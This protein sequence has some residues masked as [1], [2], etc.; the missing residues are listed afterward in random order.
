MSS[1]LYYNRVLIIIFNQYEI[2]NNRSEK[3]YELPYEH[4]KE[5]KLKI[6][7]RK[8][9]MDLKSARKKLKTKQ[10]RR[11][12][13][14][15]PHRGSNYNRIMPNGVHA[16]ITAKSNVGKKKTNPEKAPSLL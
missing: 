13:R 9:R 6:V 5:S 15:D 11:F 16:I 4:S 12:F 7:C 3:Y 14:D 2:K 8:E 10:I 1:E